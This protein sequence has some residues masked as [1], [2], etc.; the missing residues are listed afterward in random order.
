MIVPEVYSAF[1]KDTTLEEI[2]LISIDSSFGREPEEGKSYN[3][4]LKAKF[5]FKKDESDLFVFTNYNLYF[6]D[7]EPK[8]AGI[9]K[10]KCVFSLHY[11]VK[12][13]S[14]YQDNIVKAFADNNAKFNSWSYFRELL[15]SVTMRMGVEPLILPLLKPAPPEQLSHPSKK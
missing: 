9:F 5:P 10:F 14:E 4:N 7:H 3:V 1:I 13:I 8:D 15:S 11:K 12:N 6:E 2:R